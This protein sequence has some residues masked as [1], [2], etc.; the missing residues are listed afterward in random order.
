MLSVPVE[1]VAMVSFYGF[2]VYGLDMDDDIS[3]MIIVNDEPIKSYGTN[4]LI[5]VNSNHSS[6]RKRFTIAHEL[7]HFSIRIA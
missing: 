6:T 2:S 5:I 7:G 3:G 1:I 4:K